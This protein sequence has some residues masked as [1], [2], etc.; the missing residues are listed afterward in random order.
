MTGNAAMSP[1]VPPTVPPLTRVVHKLID[2]RTTD[3]AQITLLAVCPN[4]DAVLEAAVQVAAANRTPMLFAATLNQVDRDGGY[5]GWTPAAFVQRLHALGAHYQAGPLYPCLDHGGPWLKDSHTRDRL[6]LKETMQEVKGSLAACVDAGYALLHIDPTVDRTRADETPL[7]IPIVVERTLELIRF[8]EEYRTS[9]E[10]PPVAYEVGTE[11]VHGGL[12]NLDSFVHFLHGL[13]EGLTAAN[14]LHAWPCFIVGKVG[15]DLHTTDFDPAIAADLFEIVKPYGALIKGHY[16]DW[17]ANPQAYPTAGMG[18]ANVGPEFTTVEYEALA[19]LV[20]KERALC[21]SDLT[22]VPSRLLDA[23]ENAVFRSNRWQKWL[24][25][26]ERAVAFADLD[27]A[28]RAWL[29]Q[30]SARYIWTDENVQAARQQLYANL[31]P[32]L[33]DP[34][35]FVVRRIALA[36]DA[37][38]NAFGLF[39]A[40]ALLDVWI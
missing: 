35:Q 27:P 21:A 38:I 17:V 28:R 29:V 4:S 9:R 33:P 10:L 23:L 12:V 1:T 13:R 26:E 5:T 6:S 2:L 3:K 37:Y 11:E 36:I 18:G 32:I 7:P 22:I 34:H 39:N 8:A 24:Q 30:T 19:A 15:T 25:P 20:A 31:A 40:N 16:T 14:L